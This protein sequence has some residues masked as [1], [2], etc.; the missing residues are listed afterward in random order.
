MITKT[1]QVKF[2]KTFRS[3]IRKK[4]HKKESVEKCLKRLLAI[5]TK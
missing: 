4:Q 5:D 2:T 3:W 1:T